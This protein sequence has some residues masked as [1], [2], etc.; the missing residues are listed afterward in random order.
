[1]AWKLFKWAALVAIHVSSTEVTSKGANDNNEVVTTEEVTGTEGSTVD[2]ST[3]P[4]TEIVLPNYKWSIT[5][6]YAIWIWYK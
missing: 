3:V 4:P 2:I 1:M 5:I 6:D